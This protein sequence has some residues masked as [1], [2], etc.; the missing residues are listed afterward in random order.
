MPV[1]FGKIMQ[2]SSATVLGLG[3]ADFIG[4]W[5]LWG[6]LVT[7]LI[8][9]IIAVLVLSDVLFLMARA[10]VDIDKQPLR[11]LLAAREY[12]TIIGVTLVCLTLLYP[13]STLLI[14]IAAA[15]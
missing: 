12:S 5:N 1:V 3:K 9:G 7:V 4:F 15:R 14:W 13:A 2:M 11:R 10:G 8:H 6:Q